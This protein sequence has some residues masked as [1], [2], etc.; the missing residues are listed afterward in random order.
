ME[1]FLPLRRRNVK[2]RAERDGSGRDRKCLTHLQRGLSQIVSSDEITLRLGEEVAVHIDGSC[3]PNE[4]TCVGNMDW[5]LGK[6]EHMF[7]NIFQM[8]LGAG[9]KKKSG[10]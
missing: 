5:V 6:V 4:F 10:K 7:P 3:P 9:G 8:E 1:S 2:S